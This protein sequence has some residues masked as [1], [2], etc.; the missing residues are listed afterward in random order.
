M[1][2]VA[3]ACHLSCTVDTRTRRILIRYVLRLKPPTLEG[4]AYFHPYLYMGLMLLP[5]KYMLSA[6]TAAS[7]STYM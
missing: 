6:F 5:T 4:F 2:F 1:R 3:I 7:T